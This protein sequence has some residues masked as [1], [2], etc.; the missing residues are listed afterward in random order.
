MND[1]QNNN[2]QVSRLSSS[3]FVDRKRE[4]VTL[5]RLEDKSGVDG[6]INNSMLVDD[7]KNT[8]LGIYR[9]AV[10]SRFSESRYFEVSFRPNR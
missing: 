4:H 9:S 7:K 8:I 10:Q 5:V 3:S 2:A 1:H 6:R